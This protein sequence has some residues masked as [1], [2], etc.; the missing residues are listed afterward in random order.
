MRNKHNIDTVRTIVE[1]QGYILLSKAYRNSEIPLELQCKKNHISHIS[2][3][4]FMSGKVRCKWCQN[5]TVHTTDSVRKIYS[6]QGYTFLSDNYKNANTPMPIMCPNKH[7][8]MIRLSN[9]QNG[10]RCMEC[11]G[12]S[13]KNIEYVTKKA[14]EAGYKVLSTEYKNIRTKITLSCSNNHIWYP[15]ASDIFTN[16]THCR[17]CDVSLA[18]NE[19]RKIFEDFFNKTFPTV[20]PDFLRNPLTGRNLELDGFCEDLRLAFEYDG[21][22]HYRIITDQKALQTIQN[23]DLLKNE[24]CVNNN[25]KLIRIPFFIKNKKEFIH[26]EISKIFG[27][28]EE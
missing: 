22:Y 21:E 12:K 6:D 25:I 3:N 18:E 23:R 8:T 16:K 27:P 17:F 20:R 2:L 1:E 11:Y 7:T 10:S 26:S 15:S 28:D 13:R 5:I 4:N 14:A 9:F 19:C 24:L